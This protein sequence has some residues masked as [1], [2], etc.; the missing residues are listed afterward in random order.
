MFLRRK[1][2]G[3]GCFLHAGGAEDRGVGDPERDEGRGAEGFQAAA[4]SGDLEAGA[5]QRAGDA[6]GEPHAGHQL[7]EGAV[8]DGEEEVRTDGGEEWGIGEQMRQK[9]KQGP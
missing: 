1:M 6:D 2:P 5:G 9:R 3:V 7:A 8:G 4:H